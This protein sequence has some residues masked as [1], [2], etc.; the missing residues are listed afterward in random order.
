LA[1]H[2]IKNE[3]EKNWKVPYLSQEHLKDLWVAD[4]KYE[5]NFSKNA[6]S[7]VASSGANKKWD[8]TIEDIR[9]KKVSMDDKSC[10]LDNLKACN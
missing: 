1:E 5:N 6:S 4:Y 2:P 8:T 7:F 10:L 9:N 3:K